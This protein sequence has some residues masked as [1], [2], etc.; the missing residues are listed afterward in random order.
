MRGLLVKGNVWRRGHMCMWERGHACVREG[1][2]VHACAGG[3]WRRREHMCMEG[4][5][6]LMRQQACVG[7]NVHGG[8]RA[9]MGEGDICAY[10]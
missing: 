7:M 4:S 10:S 1:E 3:E 6:M 2:C 5:D 8:N 9:C